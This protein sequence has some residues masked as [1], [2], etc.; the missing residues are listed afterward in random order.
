MRKFLKKVLVVLIVIVLL[1]QSI[2]S[3]S[4]ADCE[5]ALQRCLIDAIIALGGGW[6][7]AV[8]HAAHC[9]AGY[10]WCQEFFS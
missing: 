6:W 2:Y 10:E 5:A 9:I 1:A 4:R 3:D 7:L 8:G